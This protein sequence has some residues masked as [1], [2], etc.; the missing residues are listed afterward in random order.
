MYTGLEVLVI[1]LFAMFVA[2]IATI[3]MFSCLVTNAI[4]DRETRAYLKGFS[5]GE[6]ASK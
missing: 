3:L 2:A 1:V 5:D 6:K 4:Q